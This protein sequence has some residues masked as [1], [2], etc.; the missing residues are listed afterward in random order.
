MSH[1]TTRP[2]KQPSI[3][4]E[5]C[6]ELAKSSLPVYRQSTALHLGFPLLIG[7]VLRLYA[8]NFGS[9]L[10]VLFGDER[11][12]TRVASQAVANLQFFQIKPNGWVFYVLCTPFY[13]ALSVIQN[14]TL[15]PRFVYYVPF[16]QRLMVGR[17]LNVAFSGLTIWLIFHIV[18][19]LWDERA[20]FWS[21]LGF[22]LSP[23]VVIEAHF[24]ATATVSLFWL[25][26]TIFFLVKAYQERFTYVLGAIGAASL[27]LLSKPSGIVAVA[28]V[29]LFSLFQLVQMRQRTGKARLIMILPI[30][31]I[32][33]LSLTLLA[34][35]WR[36]LAR[37][38]PMF[39]SSYERG[40][41]P[42]YAWLWIL[43][44]EAPLL[45]LG[46]LGLV[47]GPL[48]YRFRWSIL[49][50]VGGYAL[51]SLL[52]QVFFVRWL[53]PVV[54]TAALFAGAPVAKLTNRKR[55]SMRRWT[56]SGLCLVYL[57]LGWNSASLIHN[58][59]NDV[60]E[61]SWVWIR[62]HLPPGARLAV[63]G[64]WLSANPGAQMYRVEPFE[65]LLYDTL[66][67]PEDG[68]NYLIRMEGDL[69]YYNWRRAEVENELGNSNAALEAALKLIHQERGT[70]LHIPVSMRAD[71]L[72]IISNPV[73]PEGEPTLGA[74]WHGPELEE[75]TDITFRWMTDQGQIIYN[76]P[77]TENQTRVLSFDAYLFRDKGAISV[78]VNGQQVEQFVLE[79]PYRLYHVEV[80]LHLTSGL[81]TIELV[82]E[83]GCGRPIVFDAQSR[84]QRCISIKVGNLSMSP[85]EE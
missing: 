25:M 30:I 20:A 27:S 51:G 38:V 40:T 18:R 3:D 11:V 4:T 59:A 5:Q 34:T 66:V 12:V 2:T 57:F 60:R 32:F 7:L 77:R 69:D 72:Q 64:D 44:Y 23:N 37:I 75:T 46:T 16:F 31:L 6:T 58:L 71:I 48:D 74:G 85:A 65:G 39:L 24:N 26:L 50:I 70:I 55:Q 49:T 13:Y 61:K 28:L 67:D 17:L 76:Q 29:T 21:A 9:E 22:A 82:S 62:E 79:P 80:P 45:V 54:S 56:A 15:D 41:Q 73:Y 33:T 81:N 53:L 19:K 78:Y 47:S 10:G 42:V 36:L 35:R 84:D 14:G 43:R 1:S 8:I 68:V 52:F 63:Q 83:R